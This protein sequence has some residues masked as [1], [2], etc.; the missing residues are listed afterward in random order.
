MEPWGDFLSG[1]WNLREAEGDARS[2]TQGTERKGEMYSALSLLS[3]EVPLV[4][5]EDSFLGEPPAPRL[6]ES[7]S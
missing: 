2:I 4:K 5:L 1:C 7:V 3:S 6:Q